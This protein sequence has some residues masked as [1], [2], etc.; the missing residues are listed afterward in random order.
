MVTAAPNAHG[1][2]FDMLVLLGRA[3]GFNGETGRLLLRM[4]IARPWPH[5]P[6]LGRGH[7][8]SFGRLCEM[9]EVSELNHTRFAQIQATG[10][11]R[12]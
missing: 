7:A 6:G 1:L 2:P 11:S 5:T 4:G 3:N 12:Y 10:R 8:S 9:D